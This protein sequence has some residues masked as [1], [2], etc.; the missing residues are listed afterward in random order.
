MS[1]R[2]VKLQRLSFQ[3]DKA[4]SRFSKN[5]RDIIVK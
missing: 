2:E 5:Q 1:E 3:I 4:L